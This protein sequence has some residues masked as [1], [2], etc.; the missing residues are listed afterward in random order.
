MS[1]F[2]PDG[3]KLGNPTFAENLL[4]L[5]LGNTLDLLKHPSGRVRHRLNGIVAAINDELDITL[6]QAC[7]SLEPRI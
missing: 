1:A 6:R 5:L 2:S 3:K 7:N 4:G